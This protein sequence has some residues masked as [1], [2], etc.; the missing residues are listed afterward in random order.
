MNRGPFA[1]ISLLAFIANSLWT[2][3]HSVSL[4]GC[5]FF[6]ALLAA[7]AFFNIL[8]KKGGRIPDLTAPAKLDR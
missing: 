1:L 7:S 2:V 6:G 4:P 8:L 5:I 3:L